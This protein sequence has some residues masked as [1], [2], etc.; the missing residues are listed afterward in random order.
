MTFSMVV[1]PAPLGPMRALIWPRL[2]AKLTSERAAR[3]EKFFATSTTFN[4]RSSFTNHSPSIRLR[5][6][7]HGFQGQGLN[8]S[9][10][11]PAPG[12]EGREEPQQ[13]TGHKNDH[14]NQNQAIGEQFKFLK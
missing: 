12:P 4:S 8:R 5:D 3:P 14:Q 2:T 1:F 10:S 9:I 13:P 6:P 11:A 7:I